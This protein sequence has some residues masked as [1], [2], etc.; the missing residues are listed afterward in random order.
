MWVGCSAPWAILT[1]VPNATAR[2]F[3]GVQAV[4]VLFAELVAGVALGA[5]FATLRD[6]ASVCALAAAAA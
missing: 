1:L 5:E 3:L 2:T 6:L 4:P